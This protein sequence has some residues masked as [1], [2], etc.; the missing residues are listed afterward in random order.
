[1]NTKQK[2]NELNGLNALSQ[3]EEA[4]NSEI[5]IPTP[6]N[7]EQDKSQ[8]PNPNADRERDRAEGEATAVSASP[9]DLPGKHRAW[10]IEQRA[11]GLE[12]V[13]GSELLDALEGVA[14]RHVI[15]P[16]W[17]PET[18]ALMTLHTYAF[19]LRD[20]TAYLGI[21]SPEKRCGKT[22]LLGVLSKL[23][24]RPVVAANISSPAFFRVIEETRPTLLIDEADTFLRGSDELRGIL[25]AGYS[26]KTAFVWRV[27]NETRKSEGL[28]ELKKLNELN[29]EGE[30][31]EESGLSGE[32]ER[33]EQSRVAKFSCWC[34]KVICAIG[35]LP[36]TLADRCIVIRMER[37]REDEECERLRDLDGSVLREQCAR[38]ARENREAI[39]AAR[40]KGV[41]D[42]NDRASDIWEPL[43]ALADLAGGRWP[44]KARQAASH[45][46]TRAQEENPI[47]SLLM[48]I[49][50]VFAR[51]WAG[52]VEDARV[53]GGDAAAEEVK[54][55]VASN[56]NRLFSKALAAALN[57]MEGRPWRELLRGK[58]VTELWLA[59][60]LRPY[61]IRPRMM[62]IGEV[63]SR[64]YEERDF[65][66]AFRRYIPRS[67]LEEFRE[68]L[69]AGRDPK[70][71]MPNKP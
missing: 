14:R 56:G 68:R 48:D 15:L 8:A 36:D 35:R 6:M 1:M 7:R 33:A 20:V 37:K 5:Q 41:A 58:E 46:T 21:E 23:V 44:E 28:K 51:E 43:F 30:A 26:K 69:A 67:E 42:L 63:Q 12:P 17:A 34:P 45:L 52:K 27:T 64:G 65:S 19:E 25:N 3:G 70:S 24:N 54:K 32:G 50:F 55:G 4:S 66:N 10:H 62:R 29:G 47:G 2:L 13:N 18:L 11:C 9:E 53:A 38:F 59:Q 71:E 22:T 61:G 57:W 60:R 16:E 39:A 31:G 40:P 49:F